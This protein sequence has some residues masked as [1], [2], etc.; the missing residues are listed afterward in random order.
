MLDK[1]KDTKTAYAFVKEGWRM[2]K[3]YN[4]YDK[5]VYPYS[6]PVKVTKLLHEIADYGK[7]TRSSQ[8]Y[9]NSLANGLGDILNH[10]E[11]FE[12]EPDVDVVMT[13]GDVKTVKKSIAELVVESG[14]GKY[15]EDIMIEE[16]QKRYDEMDYSDYIV[17]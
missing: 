2:V 6:F 9:L 11:E 15:L 7:C 16:M 1:V 8:E 12:L 3:A 10:W 13:T 5:V 14:A 4:W 17:W